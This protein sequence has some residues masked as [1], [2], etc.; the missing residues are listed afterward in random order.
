[1]YA[2]LRGSR[3]MIEPYL[4]KGPE[5]GERLT[6]R[7]IK[8][9]VDGALG[10]RGAALLEPYSDE[11][12]NRG[13]VITDQATLETVAKMAVA[14]GFQANTHAIG[15]RANRMVLDAYQAAGATNRRFRV[16]HA[17]IIA[18]PDLPR[19]KELG[20]IPSMQ[21]THATSDMRWAH[22]RLGE[23][24]LKGAYAW[25][26]F[27]KMGVRVANGSDF[28][29]ESANPLWGFYASVTRQDHA[30]EPKGG[31]SPEEKMTREQALKSWTLDAAYA[32]FEEREKGSI[33]AGKIAD[34][35]VL[36]RDIMTAPPKEI[37]DTKVRLTIL[38]G[39]IVYGE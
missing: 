17:Q 32:A 23:D 27:L 31:W 21:A 5:L 3:E 22:L 14:A 4:K 36:S 34:V 11:P 7:S 30:G 26:T 9:M 2:M 8:M 15:D 39:K 13:L 6:I 18:P 16:E 25:Q 12:G 28:P 37:L 20:I 10:S 29:V 38:G 24:R 33:E 1:V 19:F 35:V